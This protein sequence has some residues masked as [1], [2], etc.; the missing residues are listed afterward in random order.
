MQMGVALLFTRTHQFQRMMQILLW[1]FRCDI[2]I[3]AFCNFSGS[4]RTAP[5]VIT[6]HFLMPIEICKSELSY[7]VHL[8]GN[9]NCKFV[10]DVKMLRWFQ[11]FFLYFQRIKKC[12]LQIVNG[13]HLPMSQ[14]DIAEAPKPTKRIFEFVFMSS[15]SQM[16]WIHQW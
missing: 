13:R 2:D 3:K 1:V 15:S 7:R 12:C 14:F 6:T 11:S 4:R 8:T 5:G 16:Y 10:V 9:D